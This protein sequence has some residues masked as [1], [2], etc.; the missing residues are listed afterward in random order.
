MGMIHPRLLREF[1]RQPR[2]GRILQIKDET[3][4]AAE[5]VGEEPPV[6]GQGMLG[7]M[8]SVAA[9]SHWNRADQRA[10]PPGV[11]MDIEYGEE[12]GRTRVRPRGP[13]VEEP[14]VTS[15]G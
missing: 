2:F 13:E 9:A 11:G 14:A 10:I 15:L 3:P 1:S 6:S 5:S 12:I 4:S 8:G 7:M